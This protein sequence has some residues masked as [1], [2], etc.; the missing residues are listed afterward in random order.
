MSYGYC[1]V[2]PN[3]PSTNT[4]QTCTAPAPAQSPASQP[5]NVTR[6]LSFAGTLSNF[7]SAVAQANI[8]QTANAWSEAGA[9]SVCAWPFIACDDSGSITALNMTS[10]NLNGTLQASWGPDLAFL[11]VLVLREWQDLSGQLP[12]AWAKDM[13]NLVHLE[14]SQNR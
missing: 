4:L 12:D 2:N 14:L 6:L 8:N 7:S 1:K 13:P 5:S 10:V 9:D 11:R 3:A